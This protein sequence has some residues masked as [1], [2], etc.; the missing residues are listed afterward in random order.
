[1]PRL[2]TAPLLLLGFL[3]LTGTNAAFADDGK[4][5]VGKKEIDTVL[6]AKIPL[7]QAIAAAEQATGGKSYAATIEDKEGQML[8]EVKTAAANGT[9][10]VEVDPGTGKIVQAKPI[11]A[12]SEEEGEQDD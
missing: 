12:G 2:K 4:D 5:E 3:T 10:R 6:A 7:S 1:M 11:E 9:Q 8:Y